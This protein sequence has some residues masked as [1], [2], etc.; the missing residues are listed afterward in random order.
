MKRS[1]R[2][3]S[4]D[5]WHE[6]PDGACPSCGSDVRIRTNQSGVPRLDHRTPNPFEMPLPTWIKDPSIPAPIR[7][8]KNSVV[9]LQW[10][11]MF[12]AGSIAWMAY[13]VAV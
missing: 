6:S 4:C 12:F 5:Q 11:A 13:W 10:V 7:L 1:F 9:A 2:C 3:S 8:M